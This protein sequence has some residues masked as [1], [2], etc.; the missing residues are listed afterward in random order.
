M[1]NKVVLL[2]LVMLL[3]S[4][5]CQS[6]EFNAFQAAQN[7]YKAYKHE[8]N[9]EAISLAFANVQIALEEKSAG[10]KTFL[11]AGL[12]AN[13]MQN[14]TLAPELAARY[15]E[16]AVE[17]NPKDASLHYAIAQDFYSKNKS[18]KS[19]EY[20]EKALLSDKKFLTPAF[21]TVLSQAYIASGKT[22]QGARFFEDYIKENSKLP[23]YFVLTTAYLFDLEYMQEEK[24]KYINLVLENKRYSEADRA[25]AGKMLE[26]I[27]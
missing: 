27:E 15:F 25:L 10:Y 6:R 12:I 5:S 23:A 24:E 8:K 1:I 16:K 7:A 9:D 2:F 26:E 11:L 13:E 19:I 18:E 14:N 17:L 20:Y 4:N 21:I 22:Y 3:F